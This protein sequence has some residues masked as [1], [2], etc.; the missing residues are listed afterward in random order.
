MTKYLLLSASMLTLAA[1]GGA[2]D[3]PASTD[4]AA[5]D[6]ETAS[7]EALIPELEGVAAGT[8]S[9]EKGHA[10][11]A[12]KVDH[13]AGLSEYRMNFSD[14]D[15]DLDFDPAN[16]E[17]ASL[18]VA[19]N[20]MSVVTNYPGDY[21]AGHADSGFETWDEDVSR[22]ERWLNADAHPEITFV[23]T[24]IERTGE[25]A[26]KVT[27]DLTL[28]GTTAPVTLDVTFNGSGNAPWFGERDLIGFDATTTFNRSDFGMDAAIPNIGDEVTVEF[29]GELLQDE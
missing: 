4:A 14:F 18:S 2:S 3:A 28:L 8:Y 20:P 17:A 29:T 15:L 26:G 21:K 10:F 27:G 11:L 12:F 6:A 9:L 1:C 7:A 13:A 25:T 16:P 22:N 23:S 24:G 5:P 19:I